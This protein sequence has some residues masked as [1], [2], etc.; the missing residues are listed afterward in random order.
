MSP[1]DQSHSVPTSTIV[2]SWL[3]FLA[4]EIC[5]I[6][7]LFDAEPG[8]IFGAVAGVTVWAAFWLDYLQRKAEGRL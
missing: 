6:V 3:A 8:W 4:G 5:G 1:S 2:G 7:W